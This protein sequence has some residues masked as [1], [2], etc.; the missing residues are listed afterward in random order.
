[1]SG[2]RKYDS[3]AVATDSDHE[4]ALDSADDEITQTMESQPGPE[5][6][7]QHKAS[8]LKKRKTGEAKGRWTTIYDAVAGRVERSGFLAPE[9]YGQT[10]Q[11]TDVDGA[12]RPLTAFEA[13]FHNAPMVVKNKDKDPRFYM[14]DEEM[15]ELYDWK[16]NLPDN[17]E[18]PEGDLL[19]S[20]HAY[21]SD[22]YAAKGVIDTMQRNMDGTALL[23]LGILAEEIARE[24]LGENG[25]LALLEGENE[26]TRL[27]DRWFN[28]VR[29][30]PFHTEMET[31]EKRKTRRIVKD[32]FQLVQTSARMD[33]NEQDSE[34]VYESALEED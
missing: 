17:L 34:G 3:S 29:T 25:D 24:K 1:M 21:T 26:G 27:G 22:Y 16:D 12:P 10:K 15:E 6:L 13:L 23:A 4:N 31:E 5:T 14:T 28:G 2:K 32:G 30:V 33:N 7:Q 9:S 19:E 20:I 8:E 18:L 11:Y